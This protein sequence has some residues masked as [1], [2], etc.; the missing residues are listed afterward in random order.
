MSQTATGSIFKGIR[1]N[2]LEKLPVLL[3]SESLINLFT[4]KTIP[5]FNYQ[6]SIEQESAKL[7]ALRDRLIPLLMNG[8]VEVN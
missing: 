3:P 5:I 7:T 8:Q 2:D 1:I 6:L 4:Q